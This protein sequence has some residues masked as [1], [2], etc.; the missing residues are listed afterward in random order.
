MI[1]SHK[2]ELDKTMEEYTE[3]EKALDELRALRY[4]FY[5][6]SNIRALI[7]STVLF[8]TLSVWP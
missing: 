8:T 3:P 1:D 6:L 5:T 2:D 7:S 4:V